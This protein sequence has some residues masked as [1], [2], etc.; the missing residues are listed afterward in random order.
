MRI[1][2]A[3][4][5]FSIRNPQSEF[6]NL[7]FQACFARGFRKT[8]HTAVINVSAAIEHDSLDAFFFCAIGDQFAN[9]RSSHD[10][11]A[12]SSFPGGFGRRSRRQRHTLRIVDELGVNVM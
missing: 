5:P 4:Y 11:T 2:K 9:F 6:R 7:E 10:I 1:G 12:G 8:L 3:E